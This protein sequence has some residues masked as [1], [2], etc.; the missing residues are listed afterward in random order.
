VFVQGRLVE[1]L[2]D[3][4][5]LEQKRSEGKIVRFRVPKTTLPSWDG[6]IVGKADLV[7]PVAFDQ[8]IQ[9]NSLKVSLKDDPENRMPSS[10]KAPKLRKK[11][12]P[13]SAEE[14]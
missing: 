4:A 8:L 5:V 7:V 2:E 11:S 6:F 9:L 3:T 13:S 10:K 14:E 1:L 12:K